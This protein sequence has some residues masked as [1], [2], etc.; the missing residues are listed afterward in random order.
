MIYS[1]SKKETNRESEGEGVTSATKC[2]SS[3]GSAS[4][5][6]IKT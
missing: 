5:I 1:E 4:A 6:T 3:G 2:S